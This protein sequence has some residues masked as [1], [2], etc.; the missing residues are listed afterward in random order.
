M[1]GFA[2]PRWHGRAKS[3]LNVTAGFAGRW[4]AVLL[5]HK[6]VLISLDAL[7]QSMRVV[8]LGSQE[9]L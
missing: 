7:K 6:T 1:A 5:E 9:Y 3:L 4:K 8:S 2:A